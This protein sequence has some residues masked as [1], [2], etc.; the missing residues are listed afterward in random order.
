M[1]TEERIRAVRR[2]IDQGEAL[3]DAW[4]E[5]G[6]ELSAIA[7]E[8]ADAAYL[9]TA[10]RLASAK[11]RVAEALALLRQVAERGRGQRRGRGERV[12]RTPSGWAFR[13][14]RRPVAGLQAFAWGQERA[15]PEPTYGRSL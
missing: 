15:V 8:I 13:L 4:A 10:D 7:E 1:R 14:A 9:P 5:L 2:V 6:D 11:D 12:R 3:L